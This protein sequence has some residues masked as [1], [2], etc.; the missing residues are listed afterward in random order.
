MKPTTSIAKRRPSITVCRRLCLCFG[1]LV[2][3]LPCISSRTNAFHVP[4]A[5]LHFTTGAVAG[6]AGA[7]AA[8]P[9]DYIK[10]Q[11]QTEY[12]KQKFDNGVDAFVETLKQRP[13]DLYKGVGVQVLGIAPEKGIKL[14]VNDVLTTACYAQLGGFPV[15]CQI[16]SGGIAGACQVVASSPLE[17]LKV[18][19]QTSDMTFPQVWN[20]VGG[21]KGLFRGAGACVFRDVLFT[22]ICFPL[23][24][25]L[26]AEGMNS[27]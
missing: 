9:F 24:N 18:G 15:W 20:E 2:F 1:C 26:V 14:G 12:G 13:L 8:Y 17:V 23:Y 25:S 4:D 7:V 5:F 10:S 21:A 3:L 22:A 19:L 6:G 27:E 11:M 16:L